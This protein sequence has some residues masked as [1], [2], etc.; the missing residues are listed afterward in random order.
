MKRAIPFN[1]LVPPVSERA[2]S[3]QCH[4]LLPP[5]VSS[6]SC[7][8]N[9]SA[10]P[11]NLYEKLLGLLLFRPSSVAQMWGLRKDTLYLHFSKEVG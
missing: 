1:C 8:D 11:L 5:L 6:R 3:V 7:S 9:M 10:L 2:C 4:T